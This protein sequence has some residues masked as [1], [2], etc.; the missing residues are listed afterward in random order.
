MAQFLDEFDAS[1][2]EGS[3][4]LRVFNDPEIL[5]GE[6]ERIFTRAWVFIGHESEIPAR[7]DYVQRRIGRDPFVLVRS[8]DGEVR[9]LFDAC[10]HRGAMVCRAERGNAALFRCPYHGWT[11]KNT[12]E[13]AGAPFFRAAYGSELDKSEWGLYAAPHTEILHGFVFASLDPDAPTLEEYLG[14]MKW[15]LDL[16]WGQCKDGWE[17]IGDP[18]RFVVEAD[19]KS[20]AD[21]FCGDDYH[22][23]YLHRSTIEIG[24][25]DGVKRG[26]STENLQGYHVQAGNGHAISH[27]LVPPEVPGPRFWGYP[28]EVAE[29]FTPDKLGQERYE[30]AKHS[31][32]SVGTVFPNFSFLA[33]PLRHS[34]KEGPVSTMV[35]R[36]FQP[37]GPAEME[38]WA[39]VICPK[40][41]PEEYRR[42]TYRTSMGTFSAGG[43]FE[44]DDSEPWIA[45]ARTAGTAYGRK[46]GMELNYKMGLKGAASATR[47][48][49]F[50]GPGVAFYPV[51]EDGVHRGFHRRWVQFMREGGYPSAM[52]PEQQNAS[53]GEARSNGDG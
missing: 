50:A 34:R 10:R 17:V 1:L 31:I 4:P 45:Q 44:Q 28:P 52:T 2:L 14:D 37:R 49:D 48:D 40:G 32:G 5:D 39:W 53:A 19:W 41:T 12:G 26:D 11:Y 16:L 29:R 27:F 47:V 9:V 3:V 43:T 13:F 18:Q 33:F 7:G 22:T 23:F 15:Y 21:N 8:D 35:I 25:M 24:V 38:I 30:L 51:L 42:K 6:L 20:G 36:C 46:L